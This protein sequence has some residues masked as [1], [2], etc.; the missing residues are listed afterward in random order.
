MVKIVTLPD[1]SGNNFTQEFKQHCPE[2]K[3]LIIRSDDH[4]IHFINYPGKNLSI[5]WFIMASLMYGFFIYELHWVLSEFDLSEPFSYVFVFILVLLLFSITII[6]LFT[7]SP[8]RFN[9]RTTTFDF[10]AQ[11]I[12][13][14]KSVQKMC[15]LSK[16]RMIRINPREINHSYYGDH[17]AIGLIF[18]KT[19]VEHIL[20]NG[21]GISLSMYILLAELIQDLFDSQLN[22]DV[23]LVKQPIDLEWARV[24]RM[25]KTHEYEGD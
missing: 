14:N 16:M 3:T 1:L 20:S 15:D 10:H 7:F 4:Q 24:Q 19:R 5:F 12:V 9:F 13:T 11:E 22:Q 8:L 25:T 2:F 18:E 17:C 21:L 6:T 23:P